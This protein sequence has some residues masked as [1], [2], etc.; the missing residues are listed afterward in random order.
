MFLFTLHVSIR[1]GKSSK[2]EIIF[3]WWETCIR[4]SSTRAAVCYSD[5]RWRERGCHTSLSRC[6]WRHGT[7]S[8]Q[9]VPVSGRHLPS[10][11]VQWPPLDGCSSDRLGYAGRE[12]SEGMALV[13]A[14]L[15]NL[16]GMDW[17]SLLGAVGRWWQKAH[18]W[19]LLPRG[20]R[21]WAGGRRVVGGLRVGW[22]G[23]RVHG[24]VT[25]TAE[26]QYSTPGC[27]EQL[28]NVRILY[29]RTTYIVCYQQYWQ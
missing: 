11:A 12:D 13:L 15:A 2:D 5:Q 23:W 18:G 14:G 1:L 27:I 17:G 3:T 8:R 10:R 7:P 4:F 20:G 26:T 28:C 22:G 16:E 24:V 9:Q 19:W 25:T 29:R 21:L 6:G